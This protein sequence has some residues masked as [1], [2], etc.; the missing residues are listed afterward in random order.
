MLSCDARFNVSLS[1]STL[2]TL[3][4]NYIT[5]KINRIT[6]SRHRLLLFEKSFCFCFLKSQKWP[7]VCVCGWSNVCTLVRS[8]GR[9]VKYDCQLVSV[10]IQHI[11]CRH[12]NESACKSNDER[13]H[14]HAHWTQILNEMKKKQN[15]YAFARNA[16]QTTMSLLSFES[17]SLLFVAH[18][19]LVTVVALF[20][21]IIEM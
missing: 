1:S 3:V 18:V 8:V 14:I 16:F 10:K 4:Y 13:K 11:S 20:F 21:N 6:C 17:S 7:N 5:I 19:V 12:R 15:Y 9:S 2:L